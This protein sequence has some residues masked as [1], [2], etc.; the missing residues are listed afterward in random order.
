MAGADSVRVAKNTGYLFLRMILVLIVGLYTSRVVLRALGFTDFGIY[1]VVGSVVVFFGFLRLALTNATYRY[2]VYALGTG[3]TTGLRRTYSMAI[4]CHV[5]L[6]AA[7][8]V[9]L[10]AIGIPVVRSGLNIPPERLPAAMWA[11]QFSIL[12]FVF[13][14]LQ[15]PFNSNVI[16]HEKMNFYALVSI[17]EVLLKLGLAFIVASTG[18]DKLIMYAMLLTA[19]AV[20]VFLFY[21]VYC[22]I[23]FKDCVFEFYWDGKLVKEFA[24][25]SGWSLLVNAADVSITQL[26]SIFFNLFL[27]VIA[28]AAL[29]IANQVIGQLNSFMGTFTQ[30][31]D[32]QIIKSYASGRK[33]YFIN[34]IYSTSKITFL[35]MLFICLPLA[36]NIDFVLRIWLGDYPP[37][38]PVFIKAI[39]V[40]VLIDSFQSPLWQAVH[41]TGKLKVHQI[42]M[43]CVKILAIPAMFFALKLGAD[44]A[45]ALLIWAAVNLVSAVVRTIYMKTLIGLDL[46]KYLKEVVLIISFVAVIAVPTA[47]LLSNWLGSNLKSFL[48]SSTAAVLIVGGLTYFVALNSK[49]REILAS[50]PVIGRVL[51]FVTR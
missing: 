49:E 12:T 47:F 5:I 4:N 43:F 46:K 23:R 25:Y 44:G 24:S 1:N 30:A 16:A 2:I 40:Y 38:A 51:K 35:L 22:K 48:V 50:L 31:F 14:I 32:P 39:I 36:A 11:Y 34:L 17:V 41:A 6:A 18:F 29:G 45:T 7:L 10:E 8:L 28:N 21:V 27:G 19:S 13:S 9:I 15:T 42:L 3:D 20:I 26:I 37:D 33:D